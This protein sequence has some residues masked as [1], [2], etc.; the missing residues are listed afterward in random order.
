[1]KHINE[2]YESVLD[3]QFEENS[4]IKIIEEWIEHNVICSKVKINPKTLEINAED[5]LIV[6]NDEPIPDFIKLN[7]IENFSASFIDIDHIVVPLPKTCVKIGI[8]A[9]DCVKLELKNNTTTD[10]MTLDCDASEIVFSGQIKST[11]LD[12]SSCKWADKIVGLSKVHTR[13]INLPTI[14]CENIL[15][16]VL[17]F[18]SNI[19]R[20][21]D[22]PL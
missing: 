4:A 18:T 3:D 16:K 22:N 5:F 14:L 11:V 10:T 20:I 12:I 1:M 7:K 19:T 6:K 8:Y 9:D 2:I 15:K 21:Q 13:E 17:G